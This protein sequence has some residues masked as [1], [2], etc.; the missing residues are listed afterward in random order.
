MTKIKQ[1]NKLKQTNKQ[2]KKKAKTKKKSFYI[3]YQVIKNL[4]QST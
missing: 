2:K 3:L 4:F 1:T